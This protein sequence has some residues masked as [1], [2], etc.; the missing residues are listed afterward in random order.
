MRIKVSGIEGISDLASDLELIPRAAILRGRA[1]VQRNIEIGNTIAQ[2]I[3]RKAAGKHGKDYF[4]RLSSE[5]TGAWVGEF[6]PEGPPKTDY[7]GVS[8][9]E[10]AMRDLEKAADKVAPRLARDAGRMLDGLFWPGS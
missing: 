9:T 6:G 5:M 2:G 7:V 8:G 1:V 4:K 3:A 10:G